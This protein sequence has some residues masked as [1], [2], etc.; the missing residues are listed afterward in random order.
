MTPRESRC[1]GVEASRCLTDEL[2]PLSTRHAAPTGLGSRL[3]LG[4][5]DSRPPT[6]IKSSMQVPLAG[7]CSPLPSIVGSGRD[8]F[9]HGSSG[10]APRYRPP[11]NAAFPDPR[12]ERQRIAGFCEEMGGG[13]VIKTAEESRPVSAASGTRP[14]KRTTDFLKA[15]R[16]NKSNKTPRPMLLA[17]FRDPQVGTGTVQL[18]VPR[19]TLSEGLLLLLCAAINSR[20]TKAKSQSAGGGAVPFIAR[21]LTPGSKAWK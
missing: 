10:A 3:R 4:R 13:S 21:S 8:G 12:R 16:A 20:H 15:S 19:H 2:Q 18:C 1:C 7:R 9:H 17:G 11:S 14:N 5:N 6:G